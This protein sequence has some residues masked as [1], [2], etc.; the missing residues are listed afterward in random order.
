MAWREGQYW[1]RRFAD[2]QHHGGGASVRGPIRVV[3]PPG[4]GTRLPTH[5]PMA[6]GP[7]SVCDL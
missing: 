1:G 3:W 6:G 4:G 5:W 7:V 2:L